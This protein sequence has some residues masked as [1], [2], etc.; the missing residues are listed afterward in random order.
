MTILGD[1]RDYDDGPAFSGGQG[2]TDQSVLDDGSAI[3][4]IGIACL[5]GAAV[6]AVTYLLTLGGS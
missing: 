4:G 1:P 2:R 3:V 6:Y 5:L